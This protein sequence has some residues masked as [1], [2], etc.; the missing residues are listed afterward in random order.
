MMGVGADLDEFRT[1]FAP[2]VAE[3]EEQYITPLDELEP[4]CRRG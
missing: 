3:L 2:R 1:L 4:G